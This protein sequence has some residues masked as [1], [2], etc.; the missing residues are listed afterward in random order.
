MFHIIYTY[1]NICQYTAVDKETI[2]CKDIDIIT[3]NI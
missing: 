3:K 2:Y 1:C